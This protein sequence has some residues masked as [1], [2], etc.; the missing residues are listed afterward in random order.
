[1]QRVELDV[2]DNSSL[3]PPR[4]RPKAVSEPQRSRSTAIISGDVG[5]PSP[6]A[7]HAAGGFSYVSP[8]LARRSDPD[9]PPPI[10]TS[11]YS[12]PALHQKPRL[13]KPLPEPS[14]R[15]V[16]DIYSGSRHPPMRRV[17]ELQSL[18]SLPPPPA[19]E[20]L[21]KGD[22][23]FRSPLITLEADLIKSLAGD[24]FSPSLRRSAACFSAL[25]GLIAA[26]AQP[27]RPL[28]QLLSRELWT[29]VYAK[30]SHGVVAH[31]DDIPR[32]NALVAQRDA[33]IAAVRAE[34]HRARLEVA[35]L[36]TEL[37]ETD[38]APVEVA[39]SP[40]AA[41]LRGGGD[42]AALRLMRITAEAAGR[43]VHN[44][45]DDAAKGFKKNVTRRK[46]DRAADAA[47]ALGAEPLEASDVL[48]GKRRGLA[49]DVE[50]DSAD[51]EDPDVR[52]LQQALRGSVSR[53]HYDTVVGQLKDAKQRLVD[54]LT[55]TRDAEPS[56]AGAAT[57]TGAPGGPAVDG[58][59]PPSRRAAGASVTPRP[60]WKGVIEL[61][62]L[63]ADVHGDG[64]D[65][66]IGMRAGSSSAQNAVDLVGALSEAWR[67]L[68]A[69]RQRVPN[70]RALHACRRDDLLANP[71]PTCLATRGGAVGTLRMRNAPM[72]LD[73]VH[74]WVT[75]VLSEWPAAADGSDAMGA[76]LANGGPPSPA[77]SPSPARTPSP[78]R[79]GAVSYV[80]ARREGLDRL[81]MSVQQH[82]TAMAAMGLVR[83]SG[84]GGGAL[85]ST[86]DETS[87]KPLPVDCSV[88]S[89]VEWGASLDA[90]LGSFAERTV[91]VAQHTDVAFCHA[92]V[93]GCVRYSFEPQLRLFHA[94]L[95]RE[96]PPHAHA[97]LHATFV[98]IHA[99]VRE[100]AGEGIISSA[101]AKDISGGRAAAG[102]TRLVAVRGLKAEEIAR[103]GAR[104]RRVKALLAR[105]CT[106]DEL[107]LAVES[108]CVALTA[109]ARSELHRL[110]ARDRGRYRYATLLRDVP[111]AA[112][113]VG[114]TAEG[115]GDDG[116]DD[117]DDD[118]SDDDVAPEGEDKDDEADD[119]DGKAA[120]EAAAEAAAQA[121]LRSA[122]G[123]AVP[124]A[125]TRR[126]R[127]L[128]CAEP[129]DFVRT[130]DGMLSTTP[131]GSGELG[132]VAVA[133][134]STC[135]A[136]LATLDPERPAGKHEELLAAMF[137]D[138]GEGG[139]AGESDAQREWRASAL[140]N[141]EEGTCERVDNLIRRA[142]YTWPRWHAP[143]PSDA[144]DL[145]KSFEATHGAAPAP[146]GGARARA[147]AP[148]ADAKPPMKPPRFPAQ[149]GSAGLPPV[150]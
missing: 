112:R 113:A 71:P 110:I 76:D 97:E 89:A 115:D 39:A 13:A 19:R 79:K 144:F 58:D 80:G 17:P 141:L 66:L 10:L 82:G 150:T 20:A 137:V 16:K 27:F 25:K 4:R 121:E 62:A 45:V 73:E 86:L 88:P 81:R 37:Y 49:G 106:P 122:R 132:S 23:A 126:L 78:A 74:K 9:S 99:A 75:M 91:G 18:P 33:E 149:Q 69:Y 92:L 143:P 84:G 120:A 53:A 34:A 44:R 26:V 3:R 70:G 131:E 136:A 94:A 15:R 30:T 7:V 128:L 104:A 1:M 29:A 68:A 56:G 65:A 21:P 98:R 130:L 116:A 5:L 50:A 8:P 11:S 64:K 12:L 93:D 35:L 102:A 51:S 146:G 63:S 32:L 100:R 36:R 47:A 90:Q 119:D 145:I 125:F 101:S 103:E 96:V 114:G 134:V 22:P 140:A 67:R 38:H 61:A 142:M 139:G 124:R 31:F 43:N 138:A 87:P 72:S 28:L 40:M 60:D 14:K 148:E 111:K 41:A 55:T 133:A 24:D 127:D 107:M 59:S 117:D 147:T 46:T 129:F 52:R 123:R 77:R 135:R 6:D 118:D 42:V 2:G 85:S 108:I 95:H 105:S 48:S 109:P 83:A 57:S 54:A